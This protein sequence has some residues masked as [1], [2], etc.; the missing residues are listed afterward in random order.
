MPGDGL[1]DDDRQLL[2]QL[3]DLRFQIRILQIA[4]AKLRARCGEFA[5]QH[6]DLLPCL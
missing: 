5:D 2:A 4:T 1:R 3:V 6:T